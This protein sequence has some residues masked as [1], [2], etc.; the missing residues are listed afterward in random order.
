MDALTRQLK[1]GINE[2]IGSQRYSAVLDSISRFHDYSINNSIIIGLQN[3]Y[4]S[5]VADFHQWSIEIEI[6]NAYQ[7]EMKELSN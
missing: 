2:Y 1:N 3:P 7:N 4:A 6:L 5:H